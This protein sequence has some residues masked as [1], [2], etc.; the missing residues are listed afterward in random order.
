M[1]NSLDLGSYKMSEKIKV[2]YLEDEP[3]QAEVMFAVLQEAGYEYT[4][5][6]TGSEFTKQLKVADYDLMILDWEVPDKTGVEILDSVRNFYNWNGP[7]LF[8]TQRD[9]EQDIVKALETGADDYMIK[10]YR[11]PELMARLTA[12]VRRAGLLDGDSDIEVGPFVIS[13]KHRK[14]LV[15]NEPVSLTTKEFELGLLLMK[16]EGR[17]FSRRYLLKNIWDIDSDISTRTVDAHVSSLRRKLGL[18][19][20]SGFQIKTVYQHGYRFEKL[21]ESKVGA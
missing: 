12:L 11:R 20:T 18:R 9:A 6:A 10:P 3:A 4:H 15:D 16:N 2:L 1:N 5:C 19:V 21:L 14:I 7:V 8:V 13:Q 17:L